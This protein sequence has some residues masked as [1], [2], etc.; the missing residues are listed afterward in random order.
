MNVEDRLRRPFENSGCLTLE[1]VESRAAGPTATVDVYAQDVEPRGRRQWGATFATA[2]LAACLA[3]VCVALVKTSIG[4]DE[5][6]GVATSETTPSIEAVDRSAEAL[7]WLADGWA[8]SDIRPQIPGVEMPDE[9]WI[10]FEPGN[11]NPYDAE[12]RAPTYDAREG[13]LIGYTYEHL[14]FVP[15]EL[16]VDPTF[17][18]AAMEQSI[19]GCVPDVDEDC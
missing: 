4:E 9:A 13:N 5:P 1:E 8:P 12:G 10:S 14:G 18:A 7:A 6:A 19:W 3:L 17:D 11:P 15:L 16:A 2:G